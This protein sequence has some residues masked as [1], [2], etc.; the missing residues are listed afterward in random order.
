MSCTVD[1]LRVDLHVKVLQNFT[2]ARGISH[3]PGTSGV[4]RAMD[5]DWS[6]QEIRIVWEREGRPE[7]LRFSLNATQGPRNG[8]MREYF[9]VGEYQPASQLPPR[10]RE[11][12]IPVPENRSGSETILR[13][14]A[15]TEESGRGDRHN[16]PGF[17]LGEQTVDCGCD[18]LFHRPVPPTGEIE[19]HAC[20][21]CGATSVTEH[22]GDDGRFTGERYDAWFLYHIGAAVQE[23]LALWPRARIDYASAPQRWPMAAELVRYPTLLYP[24]HSRFGTLEEMQESES[25]LSQQQSGQTLARRMR[26]LV[27]KI[28]PPPPGMPSALHRYIDVWEALHLRPDSDL[29]KLI[30]LARLR[31]PA[32]EYA[33]ELLLRRPDGFEL[34][35]QALRSDQPDWQSAGVAM[36][37]D[38]RARDA[39]LTGILLS[40]LESLP[41]NPHPEVPSRIA[42]ASRFEALLVAIADLKLPSP[43]LEAAL[44]QWERRLARLDPTL[45]EAVR[46]VRRELALG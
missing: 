31:S 23:W 18:R 14:I 13:P 1:H 38:S 19:V 2:D 4:V 22:R 21:R 25:K 3:R 29:N 28:P 42:G 16:S 37:R 5:L 35:V 11:P 17:C 9:E 12:S 39:R 6:R 15:R 34:M 43:E 27:A 32:S 40:V 24:A 7:E 10:D 33:A 44:R 26:E 36:A 30:S 45:V 8:H 46:A 41:L 20:L